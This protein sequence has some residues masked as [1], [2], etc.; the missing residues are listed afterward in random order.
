MAWTEEMRKKALETR[1]AHKKGK[2]GTSA[3]GPWEITVDVDWNGL[4]MD[5]AQAAYAILRKEFEKA[6]SVL[7]ARSMPVPGSYICFMCKKT[8]LGE[9]RGKD[10]SYRNPETGLMQVVE[11]CGELCWEH[12]NRLRIAERKERE[13]RTALWR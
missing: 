2:N 7:N 1:R 11:I 13:M 6:G 10:Y 8:H 4:P 12:Y 3:V 9:P 5:E